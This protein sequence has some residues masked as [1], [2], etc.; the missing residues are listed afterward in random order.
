[1]APWGGV[2]VHTT[3][4]AGS[5]A[6]VR[7]VVSRAVEVLVPAG[8]A[9]LSPI[10]NVREGRPISRHNVQALIEECRRAVAL[11]VPAENPVRG[12]S[13]SCGLT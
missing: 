13:D 10:D 12:C 6:G 9:I 8:G 2:K 7:Q 3:V 4:E 1:M 11:R 5:E